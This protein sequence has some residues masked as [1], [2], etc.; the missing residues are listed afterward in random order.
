MELELIS[1]GNYKI[2]VHTIVFIVGIFV[3]TK[4]LLWLIK[5]A[6]YRQ[7]T[8][9]NLDSG[10]TYAIFQIIKYII[11]VIAFGF[12]LETIGIKVTV[13]IAGSAALLVGIGLGLQQTFNDI[14]S[15]IILLS[16]RSIKIDDILEID[17]DILKIQE[18]GL[19]TSKGLN[20]DEISIIIPNSLITT[21]KVINWSHQSKQTRFKINIGVAYGSDVDLVEKVLKES[22][23]EH[24][25]V[26]DK[27]LINIRFLDFGDSSL[28]FQV[29]FFSENIFRIERVKSDIRKVINRKF[30][31]HNITIPFPQMDLHFKTNFSENTQ[32]PKN[33][34]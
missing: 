16:E 3:V 19:R 11:W 7:K 13:L 15:G 10:N 9:I 5:Q 14:I 6:L 22:A 27:N 23:W 20:R 12:I 25:E 29:I 21:N 8:T 24:P 30:K 18:I 34:S 2:M 33:N 17:G 31:E 28:Q 4:I 32:Q 26:S 1:I